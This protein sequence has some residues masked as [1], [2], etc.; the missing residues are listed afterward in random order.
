MSASDPARL[1]AVLFAIGK[2]IG[3]DEDLASL[4]HHISELTCE[5]A[6]AD[7]CSIM[8]LDAKRER[9]L[10]KAAYGLRVGDLTRVSFAVGEGVA[11]WVVHSGEP[12]LIAD[13]TQDARFAHRTDPSTAICS[14]A[15]VPLLVRGEPVGVMTATSKHPGAFTPGDLDMLSFVAKTIALDIE[16]VRLRKVSVTDPLTGAFNREYLHE[17]LPVEIDTAE[18]RATP[19]SVAMVDVDHFKAVNDRFGHEVGDRTLVVVAERL[20]SAIRGADVL[21]RYGGEEFLVL[22]PNTDAERARD[23]AERMRLKMQ[24]DAIAAGSARIEIRVSV[25][26]A[27]YKGAPESAD[28]LIR[29]ADTALYAAK[30]RGRNRVELAP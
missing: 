16:N 7:A 22:L 18:A 30:G 27:Q 4:L 1:P 12:A 6:G 28:L 24:E 10:A 8:L 25:G 21:V 2:A 17:R 5:L 13:V 19:L 15:C 20:R 14:M 23:V 9:L 3:S 11:G 26:V 29:R